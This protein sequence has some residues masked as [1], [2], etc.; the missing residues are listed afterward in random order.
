MT[1]TTS[2][3]FSKPNNPTT[4]SA[5]IS[6]R[7]IVSALLVCSSALG[8]CATYIPPKINYDAELP[9]LPAPPAPV[10]NRP[11]PLPSR[12]PGSQLSAGSQEG[13]RRLNR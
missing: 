13:R 5:L 8:G 10:D 11:H 3:I 2:N 1:K 7:A 9:A 4:A 12:L 6:K